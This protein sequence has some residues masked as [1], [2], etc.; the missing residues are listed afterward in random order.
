MPLPGQEQP[1]PHRWRRRLFVWAKRLFVLGLAIFL[2]AIAFTWSVAGDRVGSPDVVSVSEL[3]ALAPRDELTL[4]S[5]NCAHGRG[6]GWHQA[7]TSNDT[8]RD[9][10]EAIGRLLSDEHADIVCLQECDAP[11][12]WSGGIDHAELIARS[13][14]LPQLVHALN[15]DGAGL[16]YGTA[17][18]S[19]LRMTEAAAHTFRPSPPTFS[20]G[21]TIA[22]M[23]WPGD[24]SF[25]FDVVAVHLDFASGSARSRQVEELVGILR[26]RG[27]PVVLAGD[28]NS[29][30]AAD[31]AVRQIATVLELT[32]FEPDREMVTFPFTGERLD[33]V[34]VSHEFEIASVAPIDAKLSDHRP[35]RAVIRRA[36]AN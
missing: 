12:W 13:A 25:E 27:K 15:V 5:V 30:W 10:C 9:N 1:K 20:K 2:L 24:E 4:F 8:I 3:S 11:S 14:N 31:G 21:V 6:E 34:L 32:T 22:R 23:I 26:E 35:I 7:L 33:W 36:S 16:H 28:F 19:R 17:M 29:S 18:L